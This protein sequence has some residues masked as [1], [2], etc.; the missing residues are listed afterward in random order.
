MGDLLNAPR[1]ELIAL[2]YE[3]T[4][5]V[6]LLEGEVARLKEQLHQ[7]GKDGQ[8]KTL[9]SFVKPNS[10]KKNLSPR[11]KREQ[12][13]TR[14]KGTPTQQIFHTADTCPTCNG[15]LGKPAVSYTREVIDIPSSSYTV[16]QHVIC[17]RWCFACKK[18]VLPNVDLSEYT[19]G[20][21]RIGINLVS[22]IATMRERLRLPIAVIQQYLK[23]FYQ[24][25]LAKGEI[26]SLLHMVA[27][28]GKPTYATLLE[29]IRTSHAVHADETG[30]REN[31][32]NGYFWSFSTKDIHV[33]LYRK[34]RGSPVVEEIV[35]K[36]SEQ[37]EGVLIT[38][39]YAAYNTYAGFHQRC[40]VHYLRDIH[41][42]KKE[43]PNH[44]PL[45]RWAKQVK[46]IYEEA[47]AYTG[48]DP[49]TPPGIQVEQRIRKQKEFEEQLRTVCQPYVTR[50]VPHSKLCAR[51]MTFL[52]E[53]FVFVRFPNVSSDNNHAE[54][55]LRHT[56][57]ARKIQGGTRSARGSETKSILTSLF[58]TWNLQGK[59]PFTQCRLLLATCQ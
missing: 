4:D 32:L 45:N 15:A 1:S 18:R 17:K 34:S 37:F 53:L 22:T 35:G 23:V 24:L 8:G 54:R 47:K 42:L 49:A 9:S 40:W 36:E 20:N 10:K 41:E 14:K 55:I 46:R 39:F 58:D 59:N 5:K 12:A 50:D 38:D 51:A 13:F 57:T 56:V 27:R 6:E 28:I 48:P 16:T 43:H 31:G 11:K 7:R 25:N 29:N 26:V 2:I 33:L 30:G 21:R 3:L 52:P 44:P 19:V